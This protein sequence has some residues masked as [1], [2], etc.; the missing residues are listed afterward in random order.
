MD[1]IKLMYEHWII[2]IVFLLILGETV[3]KIIIYTLAIIFNRDIKVK[4]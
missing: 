1:L 4:D 2:S 3:S